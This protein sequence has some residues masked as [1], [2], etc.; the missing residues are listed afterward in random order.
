MS[1]DSNCVIID[2]TEHSH[3]KYNSLKSTEDS[4]DVYYFDSENEARQYYKEV[5]TNGI[6][7]TYNESIEYQSIE[8]EVTL[9]KVLKTSSGKSTYSTSYV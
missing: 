6:Q 9:C 8:C 7:P 1:E 2:T 4:T 5:K 3:N